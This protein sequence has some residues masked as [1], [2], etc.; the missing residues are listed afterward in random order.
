M[1]SVSHYSKIFGME[2][3]EF[4]NDTVTDSVKIH[5]DDAIKRSGV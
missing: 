5:H 1:Y 2:Y 3:T 4:L